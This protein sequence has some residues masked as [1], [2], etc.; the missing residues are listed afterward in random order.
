MDAVSAI[1]LAE[2]TVGTISFLLY[3]YLF[4]SSGYLEIM[5]KM[6]RMRG[7][8]FRRNKSSTDMPDFSEM[9]K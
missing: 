1:L 3:S 9:F 7:W 6:A 4:W 2:E 5:V 8:G